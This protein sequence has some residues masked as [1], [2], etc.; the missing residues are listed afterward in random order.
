MDVALVVLL[1]LV[2]GLIAHKVRSARRLLVGIIG[3]II[4]VGVLV[5]LDTSWLGG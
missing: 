3:V 1:L 2:L 5:F 4:A